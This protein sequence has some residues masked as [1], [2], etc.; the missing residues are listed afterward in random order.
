VPGGRIGCGESH[1][2]ICNGSNITLP[3]E[4]HFASRSDTSS[5]FGFFTF[6]AFSGFLCFLVGV[7]GVFGVFSMAYRAWDYIK[8]SIV[9]N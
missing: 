1:P 6:S 2:F 5:T 8:G 7:F 4:G 9:M 3:G